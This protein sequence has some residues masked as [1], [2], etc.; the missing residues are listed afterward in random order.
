M[1]WSHVNLVKCINH[2]YNGTPFSQGKLFASCSTVRGY[3]PTVKCRH[4]QR[5][6]RFRNSAE[7]KQ[8]WCFYAGQMKISYY[9]ASLNARMM[10][11][12]KMM[13]MK[14]KMKPKMKRMRNHT[15]NNSRK[16]IFIKAMECQ[17]QI[18]VKLLQSASFTYTLF[19]QGHRTCTKTSSLCVHSVCT[20]IKCTQPVGLRHHFIG[21]VL[22]IT[23]VRS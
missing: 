7:N 20:F 15:S 5:H 23:W 22:Y 12:V 21:S 11:G 1:L 13:K 10:K 19:P 2:F 6:V 17:M 16:N 8:I 4:I 18:P 14:R 9:G 3:T